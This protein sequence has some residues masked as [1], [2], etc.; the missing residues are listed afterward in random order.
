MLGRAQLPPTADQP[1]GAPADPLPAPG[2]R[3]AGRM[4]VYPRGDAAGGGGHRF[5]C[6]REFLVSH[7]AGHNCPDLLQP[8][9]TEPQYLLRA[10]F[11]RTGRAVRLF[12]FR[13]VA[14]GSGDGD[15][16]CD[17]KYR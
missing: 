8:E 17:D 12:F 1:R 7:I 4:L 5:G 6:L 9:W 2:I 15:C 10:G 14:D 16:D 13:P 11:G 3:P